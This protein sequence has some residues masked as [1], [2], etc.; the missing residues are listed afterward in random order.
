MVKG[1]T[2]QAV[3]NL[4]DGPYRR[5]GMLVIIS[6]V[7][8]VLLFG[9]NVL[10]KGLGGKERRL[11][12]AMIATLQQPYINGSLDI[13]NQ[14][15]MSSF[16]LKGDIKFTNGKALQADST[17]TL[18]EDSGEKVEIPLDI[19]ADFDGSSAYYAK[20]QS[21]DKIAKPLGESI[22]AINADILSIEEKIDGKWLKYATAKDASDGCVLTI[23]EKL[24]KDE[25]A[26]KEVTRAYM[27]HRFIDVTSVDKKGKSLQV[28]K[29]EVDAQAFG[30]FTNEIYKTKFVEKI[31]AC[32]DVVAQAKSAT[33]QPKTLSKQ[34]SSQNTE[35]T[36]TVKNNL[37]AG[38]VS[39]QKDQSAIRSL[40]LMLDFKKNNITMPSD[41]IVEVE[42]I[43]HEIAS[44]GK[45]IAE[46]QASQQASGQGGSALQQ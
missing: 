6:I 16:S 46:Q 23:M 2:S 45:F 11:A 35:A 39:S 29:V 5:V 15:Q 24:Q 18:G 28:Y 13:S 30:N 10:A 36:I 4:N 37:I 26:T 33:A 44:I 19:R 31:A 41:T 42:A 22:P 40:S 43:K 12:E 32:K 3:S 9:I 7:V 20:A 34:V 8:I 17:I 27:Q 14:A 25:T 21:L 1:R 38:V